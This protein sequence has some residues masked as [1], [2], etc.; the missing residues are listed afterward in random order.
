[1]GL[2]QHDLFVHDL[3]IRY[4]NR[5]SDYLFTLARYIAHQIHVPE[6]VWKPRV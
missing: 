3:V 1:V 4:L 5:L 6:V 2:R